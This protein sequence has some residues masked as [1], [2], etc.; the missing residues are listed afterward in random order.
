MGGH[1]FGR[2]QPP[3]LPRHAALR[4]VRGAA[5]GLHHVRVRCTGALSQLVSGVL[6]Q[7]SP[8]PRGSRARDPSRSAR[9]ARGE[10][11]ARL[12]RPG[13]RA[14]RAGTPA[15]AHP[16]PGHACVPRLVQSDHPR[17]SRLDAPIIFVGLTALSLD[18]ST[19]FST[20]SDSAAFAIAKVPKTLFLILSQIF[21]STNGTC[22]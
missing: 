15:H 1:S 19:K 7:P 9:P 16:A 18:M 12:A 21:S 11:R 10:P 8:T 4:R 22:L 17:A 3:E 14:T 2:Q 13:R 5:L 6:A 20:D